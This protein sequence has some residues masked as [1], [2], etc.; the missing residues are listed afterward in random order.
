MATNQVD[1][2]EYRDLILATDRKNL[3]W[4]FTSHPTAEWA[5]QQFREALPGGH[6]YQ[7]L[8]HDR[9]SIFSG[10]LDEAV[11][12]MGVR[13]LRTPVRAPKAN[14]IRERFVGT[15]R[16]E[17]LDFLITWNE[18]HLKMILNTWVAHYNTGRPHKSLGPGI[19]AGTDVAAPMIE[20]RHKLPRGYAVRSRAILSGLHHEY[21]L[22]KV[23]A[24][25]F[26]G[27]QV[28]VIDTT[29]A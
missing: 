15:V 27:A 28:S 9:D 25:H 18:R 10:Q 21:S 26:C 13:E 11:K 5:L 3:H 6:P 17:C 2:L 20:H 8:I 22:E 23:A 19:P 7:Y 14:A 24:R 1:A 29:G 12:A 16:R 4:N